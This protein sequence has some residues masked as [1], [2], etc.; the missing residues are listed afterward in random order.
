M[1]SA[2]RNMKGRHPA[3]VETRSHL[4]DRPLRRRTGSIDDSVEVWYPIH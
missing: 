3:L 1:A 2:W 4:S